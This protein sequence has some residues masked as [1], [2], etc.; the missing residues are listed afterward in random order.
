MI[1]SYGHSSCR[2][3]WQ[4]QSS[5]IGKHFGLVCHSNCLRCSGARLKQRARQGKSCS[6][7]RLAL[8]CLSP[9]DLQRV[10][11]LLAHKLICQIGAHKDIAIINDDCRTRRSPCYGGVRRSLRSRSGM[12]NCQH[13]AVLQYHQLFLFRDDRQYYL[14]LCLYVSLD[15]SPS[16]SFINKYTN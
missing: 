8:R 9:T 15:S 3:K 2:A 14:S 13:F 10:R 6:W 5:S 12:W 4:L 1:Q 11:T 16:W 7:C